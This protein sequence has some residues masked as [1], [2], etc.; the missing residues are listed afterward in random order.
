MIDSLFG[1]DRGPYYTGDEK[2][3]TVCGELKHLDCFR[4]EKSLKPPLSTDN[5]GLMR[6]CRACNNE[7]IDKSRKKKRDK[8]H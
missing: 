7:Q 6:V 8:G 2:F 1:F 4:K 3:C 5:D